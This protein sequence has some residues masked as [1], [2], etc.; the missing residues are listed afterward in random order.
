MVAAGYAALAAALTWPVCL[1]PGAR[2]PGTPRADAWNSL[3][4]YWHTA[5]RLSTGDWPLTTPWLNHPHGGSF[6]L[7]DPLGA[8]VGTPLVWLVGL[9][10][11][12]TLVIWLRLTLSGV[13]VHFFARELA[14]PGGGTPVLAGVGYATAPVLLSGVANGTSE[15]MD[16]ACAA[17]AVWACWR[18]AAG[19]GGRRAALAGGALLLASLANGYSG[20]VAFCFAVAL[21]LVGAGGP[22][23]QHLQARLGALGLGLALVLPLTL[24]AQATLARADS[25]VG[26][27]TPE[28]LARLRR[29]LGPADA[30]GSVVPGQAHVTDLTALSRY[31]ET[32]LHASYL[33]WV[34][35]AVALWGLSRRR[36]GTAWLWLGGLMTWTLSLGP[37]L[38]HDGA[39]VPGPFGGPIQLPYGWLEGLPGFSALSLLYR[40]GQGPALALALL[41]G[42]VRLPRPALA[43][44]ALGLAVLVEGAVASPVGLPLPS[45]TVPSHPLLAVLATLPE[46]AVVNH[47]LV[48]G[49]PYL[50][51]QALH[52]KPLAAGLNDAN[53][54]TA[55]RLWTVMILWAQAPPDEF[56]QRVGARAER[57]DIRYVLVHQDPW[58]DPDIHTPVAR[59]L[60]GAYEARVA[61]GRPELVLYALW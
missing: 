29:S 9:P 40:L 12:Y 47:P 27:K 15:A 60:A 20:C 11:A 23:R 2:I 48:G 30:L 28:D 31:G 3:W 39:F 43:G 57:L 51:H 50:Y 41:A 17:L 61:P 56:R 26:I 54:E 22:W 21:V 59:A 44:P 58:A 4:S 1:A 5:D 24:A 6:W 13:V 55:R 16:G 25:L 53:S 49:R 32:F 7:A 8:L 46:G 33:G 14:G 19:G 18:A 38:V 52:Q 35:L 45:V 34:L 10:V 36:G 37:A 42:L